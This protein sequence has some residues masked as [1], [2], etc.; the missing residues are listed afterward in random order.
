MARATIRREPIKLG[1]GQSRR[2]RVIPYTVSCN[3]LSSDHTIARA[4]LRL[5]HV[6]QAIEKL[7]DRDRIGAGRI[8]YELGQP[9]GGEHPATEP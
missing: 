3:K 4:G 2:R 5:C 1:I 6:W 9:S 8:A 7:V